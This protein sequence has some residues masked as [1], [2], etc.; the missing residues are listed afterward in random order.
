MHRCTA[1]CPG[2]PLQV[3]CNHHTPAFACLSAGLLAHPSSP[4]R[5]AVAPQVVKAIV[6]GK[7]GCCGQTCCADYC[8]VK[9]IDD[10][11]IAVFTNVAGWMA[12]ALISR[13]A[14]SLTAVRKIMEGLSCFG[15]AACLLLLALLPQV[16]T[17]S[18]LIRAYAV[19]I[20]CCL[21]NEC[22]PSMI[23]SVAPQCQQSDAGRECSGGSLPGCRWYECMLR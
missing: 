23:A 15:A 11:S 13:S 3:C 10:A 8:C 5:D 9:Y 14:L 4:A 2:L 19:C 1:A 12:D 7:M 21:C 6:C 18:A 17:V 16:C 20:G 22:S